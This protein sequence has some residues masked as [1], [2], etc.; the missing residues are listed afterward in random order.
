MVGVQNSEIVYVPLTQA[1]KYKK[2]IRDDKWQDLQVL[3]I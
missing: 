2:N 1:I 3:S